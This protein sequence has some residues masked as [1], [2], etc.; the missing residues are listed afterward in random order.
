MRT[1]EQIN[2]LQ[3]TH[4]ETVQ[5][6]DIVSFSQ[7][8]ELKK[9]YYNSTNKLQKNT[10]PKVLYVDNHPFVQYITNYLQQFYRPFEVRSAHFFE[11]TKPHVVHIDDEFEYP[12]SYKAFTI[13]IETI[14]APCNRAKLVMFN[15]YYYGGP[16]KFFQGESEDFM[17]VHY[18]KSITDYT[19]VMNKTDEE[20][21][22]HLHIMLL[23]HLKKEWLDGLS[24]DNYFPWSI[25]SVIAFDSL[26]LHSASD[27]NRAGI[28]KKLGLSIFTKLK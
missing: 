19:D 7:I 5:F 2:K 21:P 16:A 23:N 3:E 26:R 1:V 18:N 27:F 13:P 8:E 9:Y 17:K 25:G 14:G 12:D 15:Q 20:F 22:D 24:I 11:V 10:G 4:S 6:Q 28:T